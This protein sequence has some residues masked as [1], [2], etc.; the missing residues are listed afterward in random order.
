MRTKP[1]LPSGAVLA[2]QSQAGEPPLE[3]NVCVK[4]DQ[5]SG[6]LNQTTE[7]NLTLSEPGGHASKD[8]DGR[9]QSGKTER[10]EISRG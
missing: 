6:L 2:T 3:A 4:I 9:R 5:R 8:Q 7:M 10:R 1:W